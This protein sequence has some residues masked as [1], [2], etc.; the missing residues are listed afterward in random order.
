MKWLKKILKFSIA[1]IALLIALL[2]IFDYDYILKG[3]RVVYLTGHTTAYIEDTVHFDTNTISK[4]ATQNFPLHK[5]YN[6]VSA[7]EKLKKC[8]ERLGT[9][10]F[11]I[12]KNDSIWYENYAEGYSRNSQTN[13]FSMAKS[14]TT[15]LLFKAIDD[16][17]IPNLDT[18][19]KTY[20]PEIKGAFA[21]Q[22][23]VG[24]LSSMSSGLNWNE[25]YISPFS[26]TAEAY[27]NTDIQDLILGLK[28]EDAPGKSF[29]Y[30]SGATQLLAMCIKKATNKT[31]ANYLST[32]FWQPM[33][34]HSNALWQV[35]GTKNHMEKAY[36]CIAS[37]ARDFGRFGQL[38]LH[39]GAWNQKQLISKELAIKAQ[40][41][42]FSNGQNYGFGL[43]LS[44]YRNKKISY[45]RGILG[46]YVIC[47][48]EDDLI[49]VRLGHKRDQPDP[50]NNSGNDFTTYID[51]TYQMLQLN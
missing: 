23:T 20:F 2:Y 8:H 31:L 24:D 37:N 32:S 46:Q 17:Y 18:P 42:Q 44:N 43:W 36:C 34:M 16:G 14:L 9:I 33:G 13:S 3:I 27:Y 49:I 26:M 39:N 12:I 41:P 19:V 1:V 4:G 48:P 7:T 50:N 47:I 40:T 5:K 51:E 29:K 28:V 11:L 30:L 21:N 25:N 35:D 22:L 15:A 10:A 38:W 45:M 6:S